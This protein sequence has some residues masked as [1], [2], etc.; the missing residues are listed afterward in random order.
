M[1]LLKIFSKR[2]ILTTLLVLAAMSVMVRLGFW[3]L[4]RLEKR[5]AFNA[6]VEAQ[7]SQPELL[8]NAEAAA[9]NKLVQQMPG[10]EY[11]SA[12]VLGEFD[13]SHQIALRSQYDNNQYGVHLLTPL[14]IAGSQQVILVNRGWIP[15]QDWET[16]SLSKFDQP[17]FVEVQ[18]MIRPSLDKADFGSRSDPTP[19]P[20]Q[21]PLKAWNFVNIPAISEQMPF[22]LLPI[23]IQQAP[24]PAWTQLPHRSLPEIEISEGSHMSYAIQWF[25]FAAILGLGY[26]FFIRKQEK[27]LPA[28]P[29]AG[30][31]QEFANPQMKNKPIH[32]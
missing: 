15:I 17:G 24:D 1:T 23:Y 27:N 25:T 32:K 31:A 18:G 26:P 28:R 8:I 19:A 4:D 6:R 16:G 3:Q 30:Q 13:H 21:E 14:K 10:M 5:K 12:R 22:T 9:N 20:G 7:L 2:W 11:R 29:K